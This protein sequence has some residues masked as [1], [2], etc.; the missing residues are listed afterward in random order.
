MASLGFEHLVCPVCKGPLTL[1]AEQETLACSGCKRVYPIRDSVPILLE[2]EA[3]RE[4][5]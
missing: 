4:A 1:N 3:I 5:S 2:D